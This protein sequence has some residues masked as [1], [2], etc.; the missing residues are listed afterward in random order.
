MGENLQI[1]IIAAPP[2]EALPCLKCGY[3]LRVNAGDR[4]SECGWQIDRELLKGGTFPWERRYQG[5]FIRYVKTVW[6]VSIGSKKLADAVGRAHALA[7]AKIFARVSGTI[8]AM[9]LVGLFF[10]IVR[11]V[12]MWHIVIQPQQRSWARQPQR[13]VWIEDVGVP[14]SAGLSLLPVG[15]LM[16]AAFAFFATQAPRRL[17][18]LK[19]VDGAAAESAQAIACYAAAPMAWLLPAMI[20]LLGHG[21]FRPRAWISYFAP[22]FVVLAAVMALWGVVVRVRQGISGAKPNILIMPMMWLGAGLIL[23]IPFGFGGMEL[24]MAGL[25]LAGILLWISVAIIFLLTVTR[26]VQWAAR[27]R[28][29]GMGRALLAVPHLLLIWLL[30]AVAFVGILPWCIGYVWIA[31]DSLR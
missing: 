4:C 7:D 9:V 23:L 11:D 10:L 12:E 1:D 26:I 25:G 15:P 20:L 24:N 14:W 2:G 19:R 13:P 8:V 17:F 5:R 31:I 30:A 16:L 18:R 6:Q 21:E 29:W 3:D 22:G 28:G 27:V